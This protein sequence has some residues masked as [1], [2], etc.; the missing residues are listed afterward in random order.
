L[1]QFPQKTHPM[2]ILAVLLTFSFV[3]LSP[4]KSE[5]PSFPGDHS[6]TQRPAAEDLFHADGVWSVDS[7]EKTDLG[8][9]W[10]VVEG[11]RFKMGNDNGL[12]PDESPEH[13]VIL[14]SFSISATEVTFDQYD[15]FC[16]AT[17]R[18]QPNDNGWGRGTMPVIN[19]N[20]NDAYEYCQWASIITGTAIHLPTEAEWEY[21]A[22]GGKKSHGYK[23]SG[24]NQVGDVGWYS[25]NSDRRSHP[26]GGKRPNDLGIYDMTGNVWEWC[27]DWYADDYYAASPFKDPQGPISGQHH[28]L[29]G[30]S[31]ISVGVYCRVTTRS[32]LR[33]DYISVNNGFRVVR[34]IK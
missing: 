16:K 32:S 8:I 22:R 17:N 1:N 25:E 7:A 33:S 12:S 19:V 24:G 6:S 27:A 20:W 2:K 21:A 23:Y 4:T 10:I 29:R 3:L 34:D 30:G 18:P 13:E 14:D 26:V 28:V 15:R 9:T 5:V 11:G 31:W